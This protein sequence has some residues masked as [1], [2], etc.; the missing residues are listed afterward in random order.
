AARTKRHAEIRA[1]KLPDFLPETR[2]VRESDWK[3]GALPADLVDRRVEITGPTTRKMIINALNSGASTFMADFQDAHPP[4]RSNPIE[5]QINLRD[6]IRRRIDFTEDTTGK[7]YKLNA[8]TAVL[9]VRP[10]GWHLPEKHVTIAGKPAWGA[11]FD[12]GLYV[13]HNAKELMA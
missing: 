3:V 6:A 12:F 4:F 8:K 1:G 13:F 7:A 10:R 9:I 11:L 5:G 2:S